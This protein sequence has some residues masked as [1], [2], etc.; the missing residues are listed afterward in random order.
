M[1]KRF[2]IPSMQLGFEHGAFFAKQRKLS[3]DRWLEV[4][5]NV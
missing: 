2:G 3:S 1:E 4:N 5:R